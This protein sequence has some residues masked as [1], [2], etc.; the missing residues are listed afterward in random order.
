MQRVPDSP[1]VTR[2]TGERRHL[3]VRGDASR[4]NLFD[5][6]IHMVVERCT[7]TAII[8]RILYGS[9]RDAP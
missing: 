4:R 7:H 8:T 3:P 1:C 6:V 2:L 9:P 5:D